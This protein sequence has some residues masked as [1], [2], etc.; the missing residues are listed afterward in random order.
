MSNDAKCERKLL[1]RCHEEKWLRRGFCVDTG[2]IYWCLKGVAVRRIGCSAPRQWTRS[3]QNWS[4]I[5]SR[6]LFAGI[7]ELGRS[8][9]KA[10]GLYLVPRC[11][12]ANVSLTILYPLAFIGLA[13]LN[14]LFGRQYASSKGYRVTLSRFCMEDLEEKYSM[15]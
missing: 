4:Q 7:R 8:K 11:F 5:G 2:P 10:A 9:E 6:E 15:T 14:F 1:Q 3:S 12:E 13:Y